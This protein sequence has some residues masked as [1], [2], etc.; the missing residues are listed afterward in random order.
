M[1]IIDRLHSFVITLNIN[2]DNNEG[3][4]YEILKHFIRK[5]TDLFYN[6][7]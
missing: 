3:K 1:S 5:L 6:N 7:W 2:E 4:L